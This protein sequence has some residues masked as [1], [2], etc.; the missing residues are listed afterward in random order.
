MVFLPN[1]PYISGISVE[2]A[3]RQHHSRQLTVRLWTSRAVNSHS[4]S[5]HM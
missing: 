3:I 1:K 4:H 2:S 5:Q